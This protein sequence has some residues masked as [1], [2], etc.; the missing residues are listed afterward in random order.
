M[1]SQQCA[2]DHHDMTPARGYL[3]KPP[4]GKTLDHQHAQSSCRADVKVLMLCTEQG[5]G[6]STMCIPVP[7]LVDSC[8]NFCEAKR[9]TSWSWPFC[10]LQRSVY[11]LRGSRFRPTSSHR[12]WVCRHTPRLSH[13]CRH[14]IKRSSR[15]CAICS[16]STFQHACRPAPWL[17]PKLG[18]SRSCS[19]R[20]PAA[21]GSHWQEPISPQTLAR[22]P[23][24]AHASCFS[25]R[26]RALSRSCLTLPRCSSQAECPP[27]TAL[28]PS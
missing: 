10:E 11:H 14:G 13:I 7:S 28:H 6:S 15:Q 26:S 24:A 2:W 4:S 23:A 3:P 5:R 8:P 20:A 25:S 22:V 16:Q 21:A 9:F 1:F 27:W 17:G 18:H 12:D 19:L